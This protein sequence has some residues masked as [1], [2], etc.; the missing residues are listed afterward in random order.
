MGS[1]L[2]SVMR[3]TTAICLIFIGAVLALVEAKPRAQVEAEVETK[4]C[5]ENGED[6]CMSY[7]DCC[8]HDDEHSVCTMIGIVGK[9]IGQ[10]SRSFSVTLERSDSGQHRK[11]YK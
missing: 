9:D 4:S 1:Q 10:C 5:L 2:S 11:V 6:G 3:L 8:Q 7:E